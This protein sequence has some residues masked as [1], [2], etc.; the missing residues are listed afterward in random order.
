MPQSLKEILPNVGKIWM[1]ETVIINGVAIKSGSILVTN[2]KMAICESILIEKDEPL[3]VGKELNVSYD[4]H[5]C[6]YQVKNEIGTVIVYPAD[7]IYNKSLN[8]VK[9]GQGQDFI[10]PKHYLNFC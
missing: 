3:F 1:A 4:G 5:Y 6:A 2:N 8:A 7:L 9:N 10:V